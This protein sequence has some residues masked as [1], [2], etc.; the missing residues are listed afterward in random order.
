[1]SMMGEAPF[2]LQVEV[3]CLSLLDYKTN[4]DPQ[5]QN[6]YSSTLI[7]SVQTIYR[8]KTGKNIQCV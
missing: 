7:P 8:M 5:L 2:G 3:Y 4:I 1:M 6:K